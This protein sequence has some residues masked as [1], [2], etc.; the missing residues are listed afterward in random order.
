MR[1][2]GLDIWNRNALSFDGSVLALVRAMVLTKPE[3]FVS[4]NVESNVGNREEG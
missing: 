3:E 2:V 1:S 4:A